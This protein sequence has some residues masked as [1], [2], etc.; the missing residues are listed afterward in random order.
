MPATQS[1]QALSVDIGDG[2]TLSGYVAEPNGRS[3]GL[4]VAIHG[5]ACDSN[6]YAA[7]PESILALGPVVDFTVAAIDRPGYGAAVDIDDRHKTFENQTKLLVTAV[8]ELSARYPGPVALVGHSI[9]GMLALRTAAAMKD[10]VVG[11]D[12]SGQ[13]ELWQPGLLEMWADL[14][15]DE[16]SINLPPEGHVQ[17]GFGDEA[18]YDAD[19]VEQATSAARPFPMPELKDVVTWSD[20]LPIV[21]PAVVCPVNLTIAEQDRIWR[22]DDEALAALASHFSGAASV[23]I[24][25]FPKAGHSLEFHRRARAHTLQQLT[26]V[27]DCVSQV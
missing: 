26:F 22:A 5:G 12:A 20:Q 14:I 23:Q 7:S 16:P 17:V 15:S 2:I 13:G 6:Y 3:R 19:G 8:E 4:I 1:P 9:G 25:P 24:Q 18:D 21:G 11:V 10:R 27:E